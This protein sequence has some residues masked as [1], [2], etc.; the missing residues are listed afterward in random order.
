MIFIMALLRFALVLVGALNIRQVFR[1]FKEGYYFLVGL[2]TMMT[3][4]MVVCLVWT[5]LGGFI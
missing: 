1:S 2:N 4:W 3:V 5:Y